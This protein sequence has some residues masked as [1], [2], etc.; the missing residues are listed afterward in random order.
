MTLHQ[1]LQMIPDATGATA[2]HGSRAQDNVIVV[3]PSYNEGP[4]LGPL[5]ASIHACMSNAGLCYEIV[6]VD[7]GSSDI[8]ADVLSECKRKYPLTVVQHQRNRGLAETIRDGLLEALRRAEDADVIVTMDADG[9]HIPSVILEMMTLVESGCDVVVASRFR[10]G[11]TVRGVSLY[12]QV[13]S[14]GASWLC[15]VFF[16]TRGVRDFTCGY[17]AVR[18]NVL[19]QAL[20]TYG[21]KLFDAQGFSCTMDLLLKLRLMKIVFGETPINLRYDLK[22]GKSKMHVSSTILLTLGLMF[23]RRMGF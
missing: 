11:A 17:R 2:T 5:F 1:S 22:A 4:N 9:T 18:A 23:R 10:P 20:R 12:R 15:R 7:D 6:L 16:P 21:D 8:T 13:L 19:Q 3:L 14:V